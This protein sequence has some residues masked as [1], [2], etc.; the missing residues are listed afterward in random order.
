MTVARGRRPHPCRVAE[1]DPHGPLT[2]EITQLQFDKVFFCPC[3]LVCSSTGAGCEVTVTIPQLHHV[4]HPHVV[5][6]R[7]VVQRQVPLVCLFMQIIEQ[8]GLRSCW[9]GRA[10]FVMLAQVFLGQVHGQ[11]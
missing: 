2:M 4:R 1:A 9:A 5:D 3:L 11:G 6:I 8:G 10:S 7:V